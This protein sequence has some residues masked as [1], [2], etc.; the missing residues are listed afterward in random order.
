[1]ADIVQT[2][3]ALYTLYRYERLFISLAKPSLL[4]WDASAFKSQSHQIAL[5][6]SES[7][8]NCMESIPVLDASQN[9]KIC[10]SFPS[11]DIKSFFCVKFTM[12]SFLRQPFI[13]YFYKYYYLFQ[14]VV[15]YFGIFAQSLN[16]LTPQKIS[17]PVHTQNARSALLSKGLRAFC[18]HVCNLFYQFRLNSASVRPGFFCSAQRMLHSLLK[19]SRL[20]PRKS[21]T[22]FVSEARLSAVGSVPSLV[23]QR[24]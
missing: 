19:M 1:M 7:S 6:T 11:L 24:M 16:S 23:I 9:F 18:I 3:A 10:I 20:W 17:F 21:C 15:S 4:N 5:S 13:A 12:P 14:I 22:H 8:P 2:P